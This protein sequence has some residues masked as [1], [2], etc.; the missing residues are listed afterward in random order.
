MKEPILFIRY[1]G[2]QGKVPWTSLG[3]F[4]T[5]VHPLKKIG[6]DNFW[7]KRDDETSEIY[8]GNKVRKLEFIIGEVKKRQK[9]R[10]VTF[11]GIGT[12]HG[13]ATAI[14][15][16]RNDLA[17]TLLLF[18][19]PLTRHVKEN[20][21]LFHRFG[22]EMKYKNSLWGTVISYFLTERL[23][24]ND[25]YFLFAG[26]SN[27]TGTIGYVNAAFELKKQ[28]DEGLI[29]EPESV[30][31]AHGSNGTL[32]G[33]SLGIQLAGMNTRAIGVRVAAPRLGLFPA[34]TKG[35][36]HDLMIQTYR[37][38]RKCCP[39]I[40]KIR[41]QSP[42]IMDGYLG[43][44][45]GHKTESGYR[46]RRLMEETEGIRLDPVYTAKAFAGALDYCTYQAN[47][48]RPVLFWNT[49]NS[50]DMSAHAASV[51]AQ[52]LPEEFHPFFE[53]I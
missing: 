36:V 2:F 34:S 53:E 11:G 26:G 35:A 32:A 17:C 45:Y 23:H 33:L 13:L 29:P 5:P 7:I 40:P 37:Y 12:N 49:Y 51:D 15:C 14:Y 6:Y 20:L 43:P 18:K 10:I 9:K 4:P 31:C 25:A 27:S 46:A 47:L 24:Y 19:Q 44:G 28:V 21:L 48:K 50:I 38:L 42:E 16:S 30:I 3:R 52:D 1:P 22:A 8:G 39:E 41:I